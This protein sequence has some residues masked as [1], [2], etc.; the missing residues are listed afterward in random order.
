[1]TVRSSPLALTVLALLM[2]KP[3]HIYGIQRLVREWG[4]DLVVNVGQRTSLYRTVERLAGQGL[5]AARETERHQ[6]YPERTV[7]EI[8]DTGREIARTWLA[9]MLT[10]TR[11]EFP[12][13][14]AAL[15]YLLMITPAE[16]ADLLQRRFDAL[17]KQL[18]ALEV[19]LA[20][21]SGGGLDRVGLLEFEYLRTVTEAEAKWVGSVVDDVRSGRL[22]WASA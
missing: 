12:R 11:Y 9:E 19:R 5:V 22:T 20:D 10:D 2:Y 4:K 8:T 13:F 6:A 18:G 7:Y 16:A 21:Q 3:Q 1:M 14:P 17:T 15:S